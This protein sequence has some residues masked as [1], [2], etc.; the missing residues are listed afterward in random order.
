MLASE[1]QTRP[2]VAWIHMSKMR[3]RKFKKRHRNSPTCSVFRD[4]VLSVLSLL[5]SQP[6]SCLV[7]LICTPRGNRQSDIAQASWV[8]RQLMHLLSSSSWNQKHQ[9]TPLKLPVQQLTRTTGCT[10][11]WANLQTAASVSSG[12]SGDMLFLISFKYEFDKWPILT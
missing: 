11:N 3:C 5:T 12:Y 9:S 6:T 10:A 1:P 8:E 7:I 2:C 4:M